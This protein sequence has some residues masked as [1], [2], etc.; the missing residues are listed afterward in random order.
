VRLVSAEIFII[1]LTSG[2]LCGAMV[3]AVDQFSN[4]LVRMLFIR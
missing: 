3:F 4:D 2:M 1:I